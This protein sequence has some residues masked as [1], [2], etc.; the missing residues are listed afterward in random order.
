MTRTA[1]ALLAVAV[2]VLPWT[3]RERYRRE[4]APALHD[5]P[6]TLRLGFA[7]RVLVRAPM[8]RAALHDLPSL[9]GATMSKPLRCHLRL[10]RWETRWNDDG[11]GYTACVYCNSEHER[12]SLGNNPGN[13]WSGGGGGSVV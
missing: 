2:A 13:G 4:L 10:H 3:H 7:L 11:E 5:L 1:S 8:L 9:E 6:A 12:I